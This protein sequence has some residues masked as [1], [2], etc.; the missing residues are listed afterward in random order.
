MG[1]SV[2]YIWECQ[3]EC[4]AGIQINNVI[5]SN[6]RYKMISNGKFILKDIL[7]YLSQGTSLDEFLKSF[8]TQKTK[9]LIPH[10]VTQNISKYLKENPTLAQHKGNVIE[11]LRNSKIPHKDWVSNDMTN[12]KIEIS[13]YL[14]IQNNYQNLYEL[15]KDYNNFDVQPAVEAIGKLSAMSSSLN[16]D[17]HKDAISI[18][19][20]SLKSLWSSKQ[21][22]VE[23]ELFEDKEELY[24]MNRNN[25]VG[26]P[27]IVIHHY[28]EKNKTLIRN[29]KVCK[30][31]F[32]FDANVLTCGRLDKISYVE[33][34]KLL[35]HIPDL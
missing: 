28:H 16:L 10:K 19:G 13:N 11:L 34:M 18:P 32:G 6:N 1:Y 14:K 20:L 35:M 27:S 33:N 3:F 26:G 2:V 21:P 17:I 9:A 15:L 8:D 31:V 7:A 23:F 29:Q 22:G 12:Q 4:K 5:K 30:K 24:K 25:L